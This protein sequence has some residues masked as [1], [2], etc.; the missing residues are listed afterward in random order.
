MHMHVHHAPC[1]CACAIRMQVEH[2]EVAIELDGIV[3]A[4]VIWYDLILDDEIVIST[5]PFLPEE[6]ALCYGQVSA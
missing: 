1:I 4:L 6:R 3:S 5:S 2:M